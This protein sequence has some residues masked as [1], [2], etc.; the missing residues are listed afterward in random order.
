MSRVQEGKAGRIRFGLRVRDLVALGS[1][2][3]AS[4]AAAA[5]LP[6]NFAAVF[7]ATT[8]GFRPAGGSWEG[9]QHDLALTAGVGRYVSKTF[10]LEVDLGPTWVRRD[11]ASFSVV[12]GV[13]WAFSP[14]AYLA[15]RF[16]ITVTNPLGPSDAIGAT[17]TDTFPAAL[18]GVIWTCTAAANQR[19]TRR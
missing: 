7:G 15:A 1:F 12:P 8:V 9:A 4:P 2:L 16:T 10:A 13:V 19:W 14:H 3:L 18:T 11:Y 5:D 6:P 17:V